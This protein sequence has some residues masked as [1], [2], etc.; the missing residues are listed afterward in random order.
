MAMTIREFVA[1]KTN[2]PEG[3]WIAREVEV[4]DGQILVEVEKFAMTANNVT[5]AVAGDLLN[6][7]SFFPAAEGWGKIPVW[8]FGRVTHSRHAE[9][10]EGERLYGYFPMATHLLM[11]PE[12]VKEENFLDLY[13]QRSELHPFYNSYSRSLNMQ[14]P[15]DDLLPIFKPLFATSFLID[16]WLAENNFFGAKQAIILS[17]S[18]KTGLGLAFCLNQRKAG[19]RPEI[20]GVTSTGNR[21]FVEALGYYDR[22]MT[23]DEVTTLDAGTPS[24]VVDFAGDGKVLSTLH[25]HFG[26]NLVE[27]T[28]VGISHWDA[29]R[30]AEP[31]PG[32]TP[33]LFFVPDQARQ[34]ISDWGKAEYEKKLGAGWSRFA[35][36]TASWMKVIH[37]RGEE[38]ISNLYSEMIG[39]KINPSE[40]RILTL[41]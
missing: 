2:L 36:G 37:G 29:D 23:Y 8:G 20:I 24:L 16:D 21:K 32:A 26:D 4:E 38:T 9:V 7:W 34:R 12:K 31:L 11:Q 14:E 33:H 1:N 10:K 5:Y 19:E 13:R 22:V 27:S 17:A 3:K 39:G 30:L 40:G 18:S 41:K 15:H 28:Q 25:H 35:E 6:Y